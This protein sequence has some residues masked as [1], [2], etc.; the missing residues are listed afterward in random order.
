MENTSEVFLKTDNTLDKKVDKKSD[1]KSDKNDCQELKNIAYKTMLLNGTDIL[2][3]YKLKNNSNIDKFLESESNENKLESW[4]KLNRTQK[5]NRLEK[6]V[7]ILKQKYDLQDK[8]EESTK[9]YL[10]KCLDRK[11]L[12]KSKEVTYDKEHNIIT[13]I[14]YLIFNECDRIFLL[15]KD[16]KH[17]STIKSLPTDKK[18]KAKTIRQKP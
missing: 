11:C 6:Y 1:K 17:I 15:R 7:D 10:V 16:D 13:N 14:P 2:P 4:S 8:E 5:I 3:D 12:T 18:N 9:I